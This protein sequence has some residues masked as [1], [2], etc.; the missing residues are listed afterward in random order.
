MGSKGS[1]KIWIGLGSYL[2]ATSSPL[3]FGPH[4]GEPPPIVVAQ[5]PGHAGHAREGGEGGEG[6][7]RGAKTLDLA[8]DDTDYLTQLGLV[9]GHLDVG[10]DLYRLGDKAAART[11]M[12][13]P[14]DELYAALEPAFAARRAVPFA[15]ALARLSDLVERGAPVAE[16]DAAFADLSARI[17]AAAQGARNASLRVRLEVV[18]RLVRTA[19]EEYAIGVKDDA[20]VNAHE[21]QDALGFVRVARETVAAIPAEERARASEPVAAIERQLAGLAHLWPSPV[22]PRA[23]RGDAA[24]IFGAAAQIELAASS[25]R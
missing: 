6:G 12:K 10:V 14:G 5:A 21:Y 15:D 4:A 7:E 18:A 20:V 13:H 1:V 3:G 24:E 17:A 19:G 11:H 9:K 25:V 23:V 22:P 16:V 8:R 2:L